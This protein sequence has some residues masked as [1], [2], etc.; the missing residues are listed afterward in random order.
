MNKKILL[1]IVTL[2]FLLAGVV[3]FNFLNDERQYSPR[4]TESESISG[5]EAYLKQVRSNPVT[6]TVTNDEV[7]NVISQIKDQ[8]NVKFKA[9]WPLKWEFRGP[10]NYGGRTRCLVIDKDDPTVMYTGGVSGSLFKSTNK[11]GSWHA[12]TQG[13][14]NFGVV[15]LAQTSDGH[16]YYGTGEAGLLLTPIIGSEQSGFTGMGMFKSTD[17]ETFTPVAG[18]SSFGSIFVLTAHPTDNILFAGSTNGLRMSDDAGATWKLLKGGSCKDIKF[19]KNGVALAYIGNTVWRSNTPTDGTS[20]TRVTGLSPNVRSAVA[21]SESDPNYAYIVSAGN[22]TFDGDSYGSALVG[23]YKSTDEGATFERIVGE[24]S[25]FFAPFTAIGSQAQGLYDMAIGVHPRNK[26][27]VFIGGMKWAEWTLEEGAKIV[28]NNFSSPTNPFGIHADKHFITFDNTGE[29]PIM[30]ICND[31]GIAKT[32]NAELNNYADMSVGFSTTQFFGISA[33][34]DGTVIGGTQ[35]QSTIMLTGESFPRKK[36]SE[37]IGNDG[38]QTEISEFNTDIMFGEWQQG[39]LRRSITGGSDMQKIWDNRVQS[40]FTSTSPERPTNYFNTALCLWESPDI[41]DDVKRRGALDGEDTLID[42]RLYFAMDNGVWMCKNALSKAHDGANPKDVGAIRWFRVSNVRNVHSLEVS[43][44]GSSLFA[45][46]SNGKIFRTDSLL[47]AQFDTTSLPKNEQIASKLVT[48]EISQ[49]L[50]VS[51]N[52][53]VTS[54]AVDHSNPNRLVATVGNYNNTNYVFRTDNALS[55]SPTWTSIQGNLPQMPVYHAI[56]S[57]DDPDVVIL[58]TEFGIW[59]TSNGASG[60]PTWAEA[61]EG[62]NSDE[63]FP[64]VP[65]FDLVQVENKSWTGPRIY[66]GTHGMGVWESKSLLTNIPK[67]EKSIE[68]KA[69]IQAYP[70]PANNYVNINTEIKGNYTLNI[71]N[72]TGSVVLTTEGSNSES[73]RVNTS[74]LMNGNYFVEVIGDNQKAVTKIVVQH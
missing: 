32:T 71:Y 62:T 25:Q 33:S 38:F 16:V 56:I 19:N 24:M 51:G 50:S 6:G 2:S 41:V 13:S 1:S 27:R 52:R 65:V 55:A 18:T 44:D 39:N 47:V 61:L 29:D 34:I 36:G 11:G 28:G 42:A 70:N 7:A 54:V 9:D 49:N 8:S 40:A 67:G 59:A 74:E 57:V 72:I 46:T 30:Y 20:Y 53:T 5:Y 15:S 17:G 37:I 73:I 10:D 64:R 12:L 14:D 68:K 48:T 23:L 43:V 21:W 63:P 66:A 35:D 60:T 3:S 4:E 58:G 22:V 69:S 26:D 45:T 31:G